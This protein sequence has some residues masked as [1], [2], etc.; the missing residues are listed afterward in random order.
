MEVDMKAICVLLLAMLSFGCGYS[1]P[2]TTPPQ[3]G[4]VP[5]I[6]QIMPNTA[7]A[8]GQGFTLTVNG[9]SFNANAVV[10]WN[11]TAQTTNHPAMNQLTVAIP[12]SAIATAGTVMVTV[13]NPGS[14]TPGG[15]YGGGGS[16]MSETSSSVPFTIM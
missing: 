2:K 5:A 10:N 7:S 11:G 4:I 3:A 9:S 8:G 1:S 13:T 6:S 12:A 15:P 16:T 14:S